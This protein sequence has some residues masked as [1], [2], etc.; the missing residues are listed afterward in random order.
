MP[1]LTK[2]FLLILVLTASKTKLSATHIVGGELTYRCLGNDQYEITLQVFR[3]CYTGIPP[4]DPVAWVAVYDKNW[5]LKDTLLMKVTMQDDTLP[6]ILSNPCLVAPPDVCVN[7]TTYVDTLTIPFSAGGYTLVYQ[8]CCRNQLIRN[9]IEPLDTGASFLVEISEKALGE[10][11]NS[12]VFKTWPP[13]AIC[14]NN[15][16]DFDHSAIDPDGDQ[17]VYS[18]CTPLNG[19]SQTIP[20]PQPPPPGPYDEIQWL[21]PYDLSNVLGGDPLNINPQTGFIT[22]IPNTLGNYV[23]GICV[24]EYRDGELI[25][26]TRRDFQYNVSDCG[27]PVAAFFTPEIQCDNKKVVFNNNSYLANDYKWYFEYG[28]NDNA[29]STA[30]MP[31]WTYPDTGIYTIVLIASSNTDCID[32][33]FKQ[34]YIKQSFLDAAFEVIFPDCENGLKLEAQNLSV[35]SI[36]GTSGYNWILEGPSNLLLTSTI[37]NPTFNLEEGGIYQLTLIGT[38][39]NGCQDT[40][41]K[42]FSAPFPTL[43]LLPQNITICLG[44]STPL[45]PNAPTNQTYTW[46]PSAT[47]DNPNIANPIATPTETTLYTVVTTLSA[48]TCT[49]QK[50]VNVTVLNPGVLN[51]S[52]S[53]QEIFLGENSQLLAISN[54]N[55]NAIFDWQNAPTLSATD[56]KNPIATPTETTTYFVTTKTVD[57]CE[58]RGE[59]T[60]T[61]I[62]PICDEPY[63][64]FPTGFSPNGDNEN[65]NLKLEAAFGVEVYWVIYDRWGAKIFEAN[66]VDDFWNGTYKGKPMPAESYGYYMRVLCPGGNEAIKKGNVTLLR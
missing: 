43:D 14:I 50:T 31:T 12:A 27:E 44:K 24:S 10:C 17:L 34:I 5:A 26:T 30:P 23:V 61:V 28:L 2:I 38:S 57:G 48:N 15:P 20:I 59:T 16:I 62:F 52:A 3:D 21:T 37:E 46:L 32:T 54:T 19:G 1:S 65:D 63:I 51:V 58:A 13:V 45:F 33:T 66:S 35:D 22:G 9:I 60:V 25:S 39:Q 7:T 49:L 36:F 53:P 55:P 8:R 47:L 64:F 40:I 41:S 56:I 4:F 18:L 6:I 42:S 29:F 11:N